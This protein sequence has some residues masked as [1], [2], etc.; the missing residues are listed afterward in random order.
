MTFED[1]VHLSLEERIKHAL[2]YNSQRNMDI[3][4]SQQNMNVYKSQQNMAINNLNC[5]DEVEKEVEK[6]GERVVKIEKKYIQ[7]NIIDSLNDDDSETIVNVDSKNKNSNNNNNKSNEN[8]NDNNNN[9]NNDHNNG[10]D[11]KNEI[12]SNYNHINEIITKDQN[13]DEIHE[14]VQ[15]T[16]ITDIDTRIT[17]TDI[18]VINIP[19]TKK[20]DALKLDKIDI[21]NKK[22]D[23]DPEISLGHHIANNHDHNS[24]IIP[25]IIEGHPLG[26]AHNHN[27]E[28]SGEVNEGHHLSSTHD[29]KN[30]ISDNDGDKIDIDKRLDLSGGLES[31]DT[32][33]VIGENDIFEITGKE[34]QQDIKIKKKK[35]V[36]M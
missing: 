14:I 21:M 34:K 2:S 5:D 9:N 27:E 13:F 4:T 25:E 30:E 10:D 32:I 22:V 35:I 28:S 26:N 23:I 1:K 12:K 16:R 18:R 20:I 19:D 33:M 7:K 8:D 3:H 6:E 36:T 31:F 11:D 15:N 29:H 17:D 24:E